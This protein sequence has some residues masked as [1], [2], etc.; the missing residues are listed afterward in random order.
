MF[1][2][3]LEYQCTPAYSFCKILLTTNNLVVENRDLNVVTSH[4]RCILCLQV[5]ESILD[6]L[7]FCQFA[8]LLLCI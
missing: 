1:Q 8:S 2:L 6:L 5:V 4:T 7:L 3:S